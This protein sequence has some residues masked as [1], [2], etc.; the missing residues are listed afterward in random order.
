MGFM[1]PGY[2]TVN[3][4]GKRDV[5][6]AKL[7][8]SLSRAARANPLMSV[9]VPVRLKAYKCGLTR[10]PSSARVASRQYAC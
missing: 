4:N 6:L 7:E 10:V 9:I 3:S 2:P 1:D 8:V 5:Y